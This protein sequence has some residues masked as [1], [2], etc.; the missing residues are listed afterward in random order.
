MTVD[1]E[2]ESDVVL[3]LVIGADPR[4]EEDDMADV[5]DAKGWLEGCPAK[6][7]PLRNGGGS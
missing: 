2:A 7:R 3:R 1:A 6:A 4:D 5:A